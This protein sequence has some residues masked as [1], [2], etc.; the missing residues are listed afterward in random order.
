MRLIGDPEQDTT[1]DAIGAKLIVTAAS[2]QKIWREVRTGCGYLAMHPKE[3]HIGLGESE[4]ADLAVHWPNGTQQTFSGLKADHAYVV[5]QKDGG[6][7][8]GTPSLK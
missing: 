4:T 2:G 8:G 5:R 3:Q 1:R 7:A 6:I